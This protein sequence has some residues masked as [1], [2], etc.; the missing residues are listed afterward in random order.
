MKEKHNNIINS[1]RTI[2]IVEGKQNI[3]GII[4]E[5]INKNS[6]LVEAICQL[7]F[8]SDTAWN[9]KI[10]DQLY[11]KIKKE[12]PN[13]TSRT[14][15]SCPGISGDNE[16][17]EIKINK[18][19]YIVFSNKNKKIEILVCNKKC[20]LVRVLK[21]YP[22]WETFESTIE[23]ALTNLSEITSIKKISK[24]RLYYYNI[25][26]TNQKNVDEHDYFKL[27]P[28]IPKELPQVMSDF[29]I[30][31]E[32][33]FLENNAI[34]KTVVTTTTQK[35]RETVQFSFSLDYISIN[36]DNLTTNNIKE[37]IRIAHETITDIFE[38]SITT[39]LKNKIIK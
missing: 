39:K 25:I 23:Y 35:D 38:N 31:C 6:P 7:E 3:F 9:E 21:P 24:S 22:S 1:I 29:I 19:E 15:T 34:C 27:I 10:P 14:K 11:D 33:P 8:S 36:S 28:K 18:T 37:W 2:R 13:R 5:K 17:D 4:M 20:L 30:G 26:T 16:E 12:F 32:F